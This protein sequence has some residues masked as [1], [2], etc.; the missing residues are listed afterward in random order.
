MLPIGTKSVISRLPFPIHLLHIIRAPLHPS[1]LPSPKIVNF[2]LGGWVFLV[3]EAEARMTSVERMRDFAHIPSEAPRRAPG[4]VEGRDANGGRGGGTGTYQSPM[5]RM[6]IGRTGIADATEKGRGPFGDATR[7]AKQEP[8]ENWPNDG[9]VSFKGASLRYRPGL[10]L[11]L[12][13]VTLDVR[14]GTTCGVVGRTGAGKSSL[15]VALF[16]ITEL[17]GGSIEI[18]GVDLATLGLYDVRQSCAIIAQ[19]P[20][21]FQGT[22]RYNLDI[23]GVHDDATLWDALGRCGLKGAVE[24]LPGGLESLIAEG[25]DNLSVGTRQLF[26]LARAMLQ[27]TKVLVLDEA[28]ASLDL[29]TDR[30]VQETVRTQF[31]SATVII[32]AHRLET[33]VD[34]DM[35]A[36]MSGGRVV[37]SGSPGD[38]LEGMGEFASLVDATGPATSRNLRERAHAMKLRGDAGRA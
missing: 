5:Q 29:D 22:C 32:V 34:C 11:A 31:A 19:D 1:P 38:L 17:S 8:P 37:E 9:L 21:L 3:A 7:A 6:G 13:G 15:A 23:F 35:V 12:A 2:Y 4:A 30:A 25:G 24:K 10:P 20:V 28:T 26:C 18:D 14:G 16:R 27:R 36:V 33:V